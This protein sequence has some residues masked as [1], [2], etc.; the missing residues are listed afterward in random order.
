MHRDRPRS[1]SDGLWI[2]ARPHSPQAGYARHWQRALLFLMFY[3]NSSNCRTN[4]VRRF[5]QAQFPELKPIDETNLKSAREGLMWQHELYWIVRHPLWQLGKV[6]PSPTTTR[7]QWFKNVVSPD[8]YGNRRGMATPVTPEIFDACCKQ[9][10]EML[11]HDGVAWEDRDS[12]APPPAGT[13]EK[14]IKP[15]AIG[16]DE[17]KIAADQLRRE[18]SRREARLRASNPRMDKLSQDDAVTGEEAR[19]VSLFLRNLNAHTQELEQIAQWLDGDVDALGLTEEERERFIGRKGQ[20]TYTE[21]LDRAEAA[22]TQRLEQILDDI[23]RS[24]S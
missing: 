18:K 21:K 16:I 10:R 14:L 8:K 15:T 23:K 6:L 13:R 1:K 11:E 3:Y 7:T 19:Q 9:L 24:S 4:D 22:M 20:R 12:W 5:V 17:E 2:S